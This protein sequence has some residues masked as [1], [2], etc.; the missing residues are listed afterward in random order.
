MS[1]QL[2]SLPLAADFPSVER[3]EWRQAV[4]AVLAKSGVAADRDPEVH[5]SATTYDGIVIKPL[6]TAED[7]PS[8]EITGVPGRP[9][10]TRGATADGATVS[11]W[12]VRQ[13]IV[14]ADA[15]HV[16]E[17]VLGDL[18]TGTTSIWLP[19][20]AGSGVGVAE[21]AAALEGVYLDLAPIALDAGADTAAAA[22]GLVELAGRRGVAAG[23][24]RGTIG[25]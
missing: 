21:L 8:S 24:L 10:F 5:L 2:E 22:P 23:E 13:R 11:G 7:A 18:A 6:Y 15:K 19:L 16:N 25:A 12:D 1:D 14:G 17:A 20:G 4:A 3:D 9:P